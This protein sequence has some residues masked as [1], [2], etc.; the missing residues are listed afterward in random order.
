MAKLGQLKT[1]IQE[2]QDSEGEVFVLNQM[3][4]SDEIMKYEKEHVSLVIKVITILGGIIGSTFLVA[5]ISILFSLNKN[6]YFVLCFAVILIL[7]AVISSRFNKTLIF[8]TSFVAILLWGSFLVS[9]SL[10]QL[11]VD[12][13][14]ICVYFLVNAL[15]IF[16]VSKNSYQILIAL[17]MMAGSLLWLIKLQQ[18][19]WLFHCYTILI[20]F[21]LVQLLL[22]E[23][24]IITSKHFLA[25][26]YDS[27]KIGLIM[28]LLISLG[29][30]SSMSTMFSHVAYPW[31]S[32]IA[33]IC[34]ILIFLK[35]LLVKL[36]ISEI[37]NQVIIYFACLIVLI[38]I[39]SSPGIIGS[40]LVLLLCFYTNYKT[41][42]A[43]AMV[44]LLYF[45]SMFYYELGY[46]LL[47]KSEI[48]LASGVIFGSIY[49]LSTKKWLTD[50]KN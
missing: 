12:E 36:D 22:N 14:L 37:S 38:L 26:N 46:S 27:I 21:A 32:S 43:I 31:V 34:A 6:P 29:F 33:P 9:I 23:A 50:E 48:M 4:L 20:V 16:L 3:N 41:G 11:K 42:A 25:T 10:N 8:D 40:I 49:F 1:I 15:F 44:S 35:T 13:N 18:Y 7:I 5:S 30:I 47:I 17:L 2:I 28:I 39:A 19:S 45:V 24:K